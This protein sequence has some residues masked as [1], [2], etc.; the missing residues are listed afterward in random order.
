MSFVF[1]AEAQN[2]L[3]GENKA[4]KVKFESTT[5]KSKRAEEKSSRTKKK[6]KTK[7]NSMKKAASKRK[8]KKMFAVFNTNHGSFKILLFKSLVPET[9]DN[10]VGLA[11]GKKSYKDHKTKKQI[12]GKYYDRTIFHRVINGFMIQGGDPTGTG[13]GG[14]GYT[15][16]DEF[17]PLLRHDKEGIVSMAN[18]GPN[19]NGSQFFITVGPTPHLDRK[20]SVFGRV[21][22]GYDV[23]EAISKISTTPDDRPLKP[24]KLN[25]VI[26]V[27]E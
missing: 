3:M 21:V 24:V 8:A 15:F 23:V 25:S 27:E 4:Q 13:R 19:T 17:H 26:I 16:T 12:T 5:A 6:S 10:F 18:S 22:E 20:H 2:K 1:T 9:V 11:T 14:P 7:S